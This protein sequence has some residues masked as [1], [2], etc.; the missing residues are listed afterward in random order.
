MGARQVLEELG[1]GIKER[2]V[3]EKRVLSFEEYLDEF[4][5]HPWRHTRDAPRYMRDCVDHFGTRDVETP[6][7]PR[8]RY[9]LFD[10]AFAGDPAQAARQQL[11]GQEVL[12]GAFYSALNTFVQ[13][14]RCNRLLML[15]GPNGSAK[16]TFAACLMRALEHYSGTEEGALYR[17]SWVFPAG[18]DDKSIGFGAK[19]K[20]VTGKG[21]Y[22]HLDPERIRA[23]LTT[24]LREHPLLL[25]PLD[26]RRALIAGA[27]RDKGVKHGPPSLLTHGRLAHQNA[28]V[29][30]AMLAA[31]G[32]DIREVLAHVQVE[33]CYLSR[34]YRTGAVTIGPQM[35]VDASERQLTSDRTLA[36][37]PGALSGISLFE[38]FG[39][40]VDGACG[41]I[42]YSD[43]LKRPLDAWKYLLLAI[44]SGEVALPF[45]LL[46]LNA[47]LMAST[48]E[49]HLAAF[50][51][52]HEYNSFRAR[53]SM[54]RAGYLLDHTAEQQ[55]YDA[56]VVPNVP[57]S[58]APHATEV[59]AI[60][61]VLTRLR[62]SSAEH[63]DDPELGKLAADLSALEKADLYAHGRVPDRFTGDDGKRLRAGASQVS[64]EFQ[65]LFPYEGMGGASP[66]EMRTLLMNAAQRGECLSPL[67]VI[68][69]I[70]QLCEQDD[71]EFLREEPDAG[72][73]DPVAF[74]GQVRKRW[75]SVFDT[76]LRA[77]TGLVEA[78]EHQR[79]F[80]RYVTHVSLWVKGE[81]YQDTVT[82]DL[83]DPD[84]KLMERIEATLDVQ[85]AEA[86]R[87]SIIGT[88]AAHAIDHPGT[89]VDHAKL[90]RQH[91]SRLSAAYFSDHREQVAQILADMVSILSAESEGLSTEAEQ[92]AQAA[93]S[94]LRS[95]HGY[96]DVCLR[97]T[98][99]VLQQECYAA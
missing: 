4:L 89:D 84:T 32:G 80:E 18:H 1:S 58:V 34:R 82:G 99:A 39:D 94:R 77:S 91:M 65:H 78:A 86:F 50:R 28:Q 20:R 22:A 44:E 61:A 67:A 43:L 51:E 24:R 53:L 19:P 92:A 57:G 7:G 60:W 55:I 72:Y 30:D 8:R 2:F 23:R 81:R 90:F 10:Q 45:S 83:S 71:Y 64:E 35:A 56:Q 14:G 70:E 13:E 15:H 68:D 47:V 25:L 17:F 96:C 6:F 5:A 40:L 52:H 33:R 85:D 63:Y 76:E 79:M 38:S 36:H 88:I 37:L 69:Q 9:K 87:H 31:Y 75:L 66:R 21:S 27:Y 41:L 74:A 73:R 16:S 26:Q 97:E 29:Y 48:N 11:I 3:T 59:A 54:L 49:N 93:L 46:P 12:Q 42:E 95:E 98:L 62:R